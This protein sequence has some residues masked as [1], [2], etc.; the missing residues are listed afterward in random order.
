MMTYTPRMCEALQGAPVPYSI[1]P[2]RHVDPETWADEVM[3]HPF[4]Y[5]DCVKTARKIKAAYA[6]IDEA[7]QWLHASS[8]PWWLRD[9]CADVVFGSL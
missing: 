9:M 8:V 6:N 3:R 1:V 5:H 4:E 7:S 2:D